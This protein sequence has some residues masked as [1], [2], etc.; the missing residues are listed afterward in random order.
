M[1]VE[2]EAR[3]KLR[4]V[5]R[6]LQAGS[7]GRG[8]IQQGGTP[9]RRKQWVLCPGLQSPSSHLPHRPWGARWSSSSR[10]S[11]HSEAWGQPAQ[12][13]GGRR[14]CRWS[15]GM[16]RGRESAA[17]LLVSP[18][19][20]P[21]FPLWALGPWTLTVP[22]TSS[23]QT[24]G[25]LRGLD[26]PPC[27]RAGG[28]GALTNGAFPAPPR[29]ARLVEGAGNM[30]PPLAGPHPHCPHLLSQQGAIPQEGL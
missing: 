14:S 27:P 8:A 1:A 4:G 17:A 16:G 15:C 20:H 22:P 2:G 7:R 19:L 12:G 29:P 23:A 3:H 21:A 28:K 5:P 24:T 18:V 25:S 11:R 9:L 13:C 26:P 30:A 10:G 6:A